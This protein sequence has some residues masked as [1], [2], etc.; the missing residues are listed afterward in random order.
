MIVE[1]KKSQHIACR[2]GWFD[3]LTRTIFSLSKAEG[4]GEEVDKLEDD[5]NEAIKDLDEQFEAE[6]N[7]AIEHGRYIIWVALILDFDT[8]HIDDSVFNLG[9][10]KGGH[11]HL[12]T[13]E[14]K[15]PNISLFT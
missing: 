12:I 4:A 2:E 15:T 11:F 6:K 14:N 5:F 3:N 10:F 13:N 1:M 8:Y 9:N 7:Q